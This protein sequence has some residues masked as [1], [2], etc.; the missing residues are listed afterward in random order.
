V[1]YVSQGHTGLGKERVE[2]FGG[3][4]SIVI[5]D[6]TMLECHGVPGQKRQRR[7]S[8][9]KGHYE[10]LAHFHRA[11]TGAGPLEVTAEDATGLWC[12]AARRSLRAVHDLIA[13][14]RFPVGDLRVWWRR[15]VEGE[16]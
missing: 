4:Q 10:L 6:F 7:R 9:D 16:R 8:I 12:R 1:L 2:I 5:D 15:Y 13:S 3:G 14:S 11:V